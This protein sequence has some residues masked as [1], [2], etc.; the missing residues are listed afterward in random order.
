MIKQAY[1]NVENPVFA[2]NFELKPV[3]IDAQCIAYL[4]WYGI[5]T[6]IANPNLYALNIHN[7]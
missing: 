3:K 7:D 4:V 5:E 1:Y 2:L 6:C